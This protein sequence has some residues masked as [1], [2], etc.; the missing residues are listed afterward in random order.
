M[1]NA[2]YI[3]TQYN[4]NITAR[5]GVLPGKVDFN[6]AGPVFFACWYVGDMATW[7]PR[8]VSKTQKPKPYTQ[9]PKP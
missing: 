6:R 8:L 4:D 3:Y 5:T 1:Y 2:I 9:T 7:L